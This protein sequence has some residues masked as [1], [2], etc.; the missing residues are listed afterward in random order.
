MNRQDNREA[1]QKLNRVCEVPLYTSHYICKDKDDLS[2]ITI[3]T[4]KIKEQK[5]KKIDRKKKN[6]GEK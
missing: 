4:S 2:E 1:T 6:Y 3:K 5:R